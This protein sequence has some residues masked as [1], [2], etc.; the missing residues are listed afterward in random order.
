[1]PPEHFAK[2][3]IVDDDQDVRRLLA[4]VLRHDYS[5]EEAASG[6][7][8]LAKLGEFA[9]HIVLLD[10]MMPGIDGY[11]TCRRIK[12]HPGRERPQVIMVSAKSSRQEQL[13]GYEAGADDYVVKPI[14]PTELLSRVRL[15]CRLRDATAEMASIRTQL[16]AQNIELKQLVEERRLE[17]LALQ[18]V[19][20]FTMARVAE[21][22]DKETG[23]HLV[24][25]RSYS[26]MI[27]EQLGRESPYADQIDSRFLEDLFRSSPLH[28]IGKVG[29]PDDILLKP[30]RLT[31]KEFATMQ[32][33]T[34]LGANILD[35]VV[36][37]MQHGGFLAMAAII[38]RFH[39]ERFDGKGYP[40]ELVGQ[41]IPLAA[42]IVSLADVFDALTSVRPYKQAWT[43]ARAKSTIE[44][45]A[46]SQFDPIVVEAFLNRFD[47]I[48]ELY[49]MYREPPSVTVGAVSFREYESV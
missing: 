32:Q 8:A 3:M 4:N 7:E 21:F 14:D 31:P 13:R 35:E 44:A 16:D 10:V 9:P 37:N 34:I 20:I 27:A 36:L 18:D 47:D 33:H 22:R 45:G 41:E 28:D 46:N 12:A 2:I 17:T 39:H 6:E 26:Q 49:E 24:R 48:L 5:L 43:P 25:M 19:A 1:M 38:A 11:D 15:H 30:G 23:N 29:I 42:R 40:A